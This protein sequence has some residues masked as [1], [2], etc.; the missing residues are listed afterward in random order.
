MAREADQ[1][2]RVTGRTPWDA[3]V[4]ISN[5]FAPPILIVAVVAWVVYEYRKSDREYVAK[6]D[7]ARTQA[8]EN[9]MNR[10]DQ[11]NDNL[12]K[13]YQ[14][15]QSVT[16]VGIENFRDVSNLEKQSVARMAELSKKEAIQV[17]EIE[18]SQV[19]LEATQKELAERQLQ[20]NE[21]QSMLNEARKQRDEH[22][23]RLSESQN[24]L[25]ETQ[26][27][28]DE[29]Q[30]QL[31]ETQK[32]LDDKKKERKEVD[33]YL[34]S[35]ET[36]FAAATIYLSSASIS[37]PETGALWTGKLGELSAKY[38][39]GGRP[40]GTVSGGV[41]YGSYQMTSRPNGGTVARFINDSAFPWRDRFASLEPESPEFSEQ[42]MA[43][44]KEAPA[45]FFEAQHDYIKRTHYDPLVRKIEAEDGINIDGRSRALQNAVWSTALQHGPNTP[46]VHRALAK[47][48]SDGSINPDEQEFDQK[49]VEAIYAE[50]SKKSADGNLVYFARN[51]RAVQAGVERRFEEELRN[52]LKELESQRKQA[53]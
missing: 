29:R 4:E 26:R 44:A 45:A 7:E 35:V 25:A 2:Q 23:S 21:A 40:P 14:A 27:Q 53:G 34:A 50:R 6:L 41:S 20:L 39:I 31:A 32:E 47:L 49:L 52:A 36:N 48:R 38:E 17:K 42:W 43:L 3:L 11:L 37:V 16:D 12:I 24:M 19:H 10:L 28:R 9:Y 22:Q 46:V 5:R 1:S 13:T 18:E 15:M 8:S 30:R 33:E 51:S